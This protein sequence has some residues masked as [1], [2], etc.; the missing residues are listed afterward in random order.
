MGRHG[1]GALPGHYRL[2]PYR[3]GR[4]TAARKTPQQRGL[5][6]RNKGAAYEN[7]I[8]AVFS[9]LLN[10]KVTRKLGQARDSG[11]DIHIGPLVVE[12][13]RRKSIGSIDKW[14]EQ[15]IAGTPEGKTPCVIA[16]SDHKASVISMRLTDF[17]DIVTHA[18]VCGP[19]LWR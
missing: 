13:K 8:C 10:V 3:G 11:N 14:L 6:S 1:R 2:R 4:V 5:M 15:A 18:M 7:E 9:K 17:L 19:E 12:A 16:R